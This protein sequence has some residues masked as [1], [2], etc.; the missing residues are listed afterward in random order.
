MAKEPFAGIKHPLTRA[1][2]QEANQGNQLQSSSR[3]T[4]LLLIDFYGLSV[5]THFYWTQRYLMDCQNA[6][7]T[8]LCMCCKP[9]AWNTNECCKS[10]TRAASRQVDSN[11]SFLVGCSCAG[12]KGQSSWS[13]PMEDYQL[14]S[15]TTGES[16]RLEHAQSQPAG[17]R[18]AGEQAWGKEDK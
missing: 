13:C 17:T 9:I 6:A 18:G 2:A 12:D 15:E 3:L 5:T 8:S 7:E 1:F 14:H 11:S 16:Q 10:S 4:A